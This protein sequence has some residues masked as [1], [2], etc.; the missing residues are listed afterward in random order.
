MKTPDSGRSCLSSRPPSAKWRCI[1]G[2]SHSGW[3][4]T[5]A[6]SIA[7]RRWSPNCS[8]CSS[9][10]AP[11][12]CVRKRRARCAKLR[13]ASVPCTRR[14]QRFWVSSMT[15]YCRSRCASLPPVNR[16][17]LHFPGKPARCCRQ[18]PPARRVAE[19]SARWAATCRSRWSS[20][21]APLRS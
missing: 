12:S 13:S 7:L 14:W 16:Y 9:A 20:S 5:P 4:L 19:S 10:K 8:E 15:R 3:R 11:K 2:C 18:K 1:I 21:S 17:L 6:K